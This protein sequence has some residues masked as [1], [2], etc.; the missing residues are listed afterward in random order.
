LTGTGS[1]A[2]SGDFNPDIVGNV[3][4]DQAWGL[5]QLS[6]AAHLLNASYNLL[7]TGGVPIGGNTGLNDSELSGHPDSKWGGS[8]MAALNIKNLPTGQGDDIKIDASFAHGDTKNVISTSSGS[9][10]F[11]MFGG[12]NRPGAYQSIGFGQT[13]DAVFLPAFFGGTGDLKLVNSY[14]IRG[15][16]NHNWDAYWST[17]VFGS[18]SAVRYG[19][20]I[21]AGPG[22]FNFDPTTARGQYCASFT[23]SLVPGSLAA[24]GVKQFS[25]D[26]TCNPDYN[27]AMLGTVTR[28]TPV[29]NL[30]FSAEVLYFHLDQMMSGA[31]V[32]TVPA[33]AAPPK[34]NLIYEFK[35]QNAVSLNVRVQRNF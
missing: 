15:A 33:G 13:A 20:N 25:A 18:Y 12:T 31:M 5:F 34:P 27:V 17:S 10:S 23:N 14:G 9:P 35:D 7:G 6:G 16:F 21:Y 1:N 8:V 24:A 19:G 30:T 4:V 11:A 29:K 22:L 28:W 2:Y 32:S 3:R 26:F